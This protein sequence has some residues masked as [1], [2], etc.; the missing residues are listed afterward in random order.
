[1]KSQNVAIYSRIAS[2]NRELDLIVLQENSLLRYAQEN[3]YFD[4][5]CYHDNGVSGLS[6]DRPGMNE[7]MD[8]IRNRVIDTVIVKDSNRIARGSLP[9]I[10]WMQFTQAHGVTVISMIEGNIDTSLSF[11]LALLEQV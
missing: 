7:L 5:V 10:E 8:D 9:L 3:G 1:M 6:L 11:N 2:V 4:C